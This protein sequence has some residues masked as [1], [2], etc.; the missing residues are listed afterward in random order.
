MGATFGSGV[1]DNFV[2]ICDG[3]LLAVL[4]MRT[5]PENVFDSVAFPTVVAGVVWGEVCCVE[6]ILGSDRVCYDGS[7]GEKIFWVLLSV[8][9]GEVLGGCVEV[10]QFAYIC[11]VFSFRLVPAAP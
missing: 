1:V 2:Y 3:E 7:E 4:V 9:G 8:L 10:N 5:V 6:S 11:E